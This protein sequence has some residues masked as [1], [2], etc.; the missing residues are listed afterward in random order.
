M[1]KRMVNVVPRPTSL[2]TSMVPP[3][4]STIAV[5]IGRPQ[6]L[7]GIPAGLRLKSNDQT[8]GRSSGAMP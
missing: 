3:R 8:L 6:P 1:G 5:I 2:V 7:P 4:P